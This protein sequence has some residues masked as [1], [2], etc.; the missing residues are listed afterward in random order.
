MQSDGNLVVIAPGNHPV[1]ATGTSGWTNSDVELQNDGNIVVYSPGHIA[2]WAS[3]TQTGSTSL[4]DR[5]V[6]IAT[7]EAAN[8][9]H[10]HEAGTNC[11]YYSGA[12]GVGTPCANGWR[13]Q[14]W[15]ADF[16]RWVWGQAGAQTGGL[17][18][19]AISFQNYGNSHGTWHPGSSL[20]GVQ[21][22]D[23]IGYNFGGS[24]TDDHVG[25]VTSVSASTVTTVEGNY[26]DQVKARTV[27]RGA[28][29][30]SGYTH[31][32]G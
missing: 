6:A 15:C 17:N 7:N 18:S 9:S 22:G 4:G 8:S 11:N 5:I 26:S 13:T 10:N 1:W 16:S 25:V 29:G 24:T 19:Q 23:I 14:E 12:L 20:S 2:R 21:P 3:G 31:P 30:V 28:N 32:V 27:T